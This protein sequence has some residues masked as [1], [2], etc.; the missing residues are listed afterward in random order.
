MPVIGGD[1]FPFKKPDPR[2]ILATIE[3]AGGDP[4]A[5]VMIGDSRSDIDAA[6]AAGL[7]VVAVSFGYT[8]T[9]VAKLGPDV[10]IDHFDE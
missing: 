6:K 9:P 8:D 1:T 3:R 7:P 5:A 10:I 4:D 2:H